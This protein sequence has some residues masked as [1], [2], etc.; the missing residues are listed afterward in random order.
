VVVDIDRDGALDV[1]TGDSSAVAILHGDPEAPG[2]FGAV[3][4]FFMV[5]DA[6]NGTRS[7][8]T[9]LAGDVDGDGW[10]DLV[11]ANASQS[12][13][14][15]QSPGNE[16]RFPDAYAVQGHGIYTS[17]PFIRD[18]ASGTLVDFDADGKL[19]YVFAD[20]ALGTRLVRGR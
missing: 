13:V 1:V 20:P 18:S 16:V 2:Q 10:P 14:L 11:L 17:G 5:A 6:D 12:F 3:E 9:I 4:K 19:D 8:S 7:F 15:R